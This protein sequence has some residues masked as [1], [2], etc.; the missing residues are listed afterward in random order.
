MHAPA[1]ILPLQSQADCPAELRGSIASLAALGV[2]HV[3]VVPARNED[4][5][6]ERIVLGAHLFENV[7]YLPNG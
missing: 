2:G 5:N 1:T 7:F 3:P 4:V 6:R